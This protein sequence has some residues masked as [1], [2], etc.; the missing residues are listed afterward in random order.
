MSEFIFND[1]P[2]RSTS[3]F[4]PEAAYVAF[5]AQYRASLSVS[6]ARIFFLNQKKAKDRLRQTSQPNVNLTFG[7]S[8]FPVVNNHF[9]Q[10]Q[11]NP[12]PDNG[13]T[14][15]RLSGYLARWL[16]DQI[17]VGGSV[18]EAEIRG[19]IVIPLAE[20][21]GCTWND[22]NAMYL[23]FAAGTE[24]FLQTF[25]FFPLAIEMQRVL[26]D[27]M[28]VNFMK[29]VIRQRYGTL[30]AEQW[31]RQE[32]TAV[33][34]AFNAVGLLPWARSGFSPVAR[35]FLRNFGINI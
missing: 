14:L 6:V 9:P 35:E 27:G 32:V 15:H 30:T 25:T 29:K 17:R 4:D 26:K 2:Q 3:T 24:M 19:A 5:E 23:A 22:G 31:M 33:T 18:R 8:V 10:F 13:L 20:I 11:S 7:Q 21:K 1:V 16:M 28:D 12:V 34:A